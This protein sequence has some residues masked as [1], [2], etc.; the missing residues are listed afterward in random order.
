MLQVARRIAHPWIW[1]ATLVLAAAP[2]EATFSIVAR[3]SVTGDIGVAVQSHYFSVGP[4]VP[5][6]EPGIGAVATQSLVEVSYGPK[7][8]R[9]MREGRSATRA[10]DELLAQDQYRDV[11]QVAMIDANG[12]VAVHTG[13]K[14]IADAGDHAGAQYSV[15]ANLMANATVWP[16]MAKAYETSK[17][18]LA[19][20]LLDALEAGQRAG[21]DMRGQQSAAIVIVKGKRSSRPWADRI[22]DLRVEDHGKPIAELRR[23]VTLWRAYRSV[24]EGDGLITEGKTEEAMKAYSAA[25]RMAPDNTE[26]V[27]WQ[28][29]ALW[30]LGRE[31]DAAPLFR[32]VFAKERRWVDLVPRLVPAGLLADDPAGLKRIQALAPAAPKKRRR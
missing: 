8:L 22:L 27:F 10:L 32:K 14:C 31:R 7:G 2:A 20:R 21:G 29:A 11:R 1:I 5:W 28:A 24:D 19:E 16:A 3:D 4:I 6:A 17:G 25:A 15:Q 13:E 26:I 23:L 12:S 9:L 30:K 18:D